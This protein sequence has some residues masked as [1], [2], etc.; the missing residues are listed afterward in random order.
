MTLEETP[1]RYNMEPAVREALVDIAT[2]IKNPTSQNWA[3]WFAKVAKIYERG[4]S[5]VEL[6]SWETL[7]G[8]AERVYFW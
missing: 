8:H 5:S 1:S 7:S 4:D 3:A 6:S 2:R